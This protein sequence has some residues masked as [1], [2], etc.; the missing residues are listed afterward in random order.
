MLADIHTGAQTE[1]CTEVS[2]CQKY[3][4]IY[5]YIV[6][7]CKEPRHQILLPAVCQKDTDIPC[8]LHPSTFE[9]REHAY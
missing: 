9:A 5:I 2:L 6:E 3:I 4:Y 8:C 1:D 7:N